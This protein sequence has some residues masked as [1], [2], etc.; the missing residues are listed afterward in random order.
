MHTGRT[1]ME[2]R[3]R[4]SVPSPAFTPTARFVWEQA[5]LPPF[6]DFEIHLPAEA[7][8]LGGA[9]GRL[10]APADTRTHPC[11]VSVNQS[12]TRLSEVALTRLREM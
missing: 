6:R 8:S 12:E 11:V 10:G 4:H 5:H 1:V 2:G 3:G 7:T 9:Q